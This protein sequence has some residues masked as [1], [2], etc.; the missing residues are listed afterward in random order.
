[1]SCVHGSAISF[2]YDD[3]DSSGFNWTGRRL[4]P[5]AKRRG[6]VEHITFSGADQDRAVAYDYDAL[7][8]LS[9]E[10]IRKSGDAGWPAFAPTML[11]SSPVSGDILYDSAVGYSDSGGYDKVGN[12]GS[13]TSSGVNVVT[14]SGIQALQNQSGLNYDANDRMN[15][16]A[17]PPSYDANGNTKYQA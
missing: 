5:A 9:A 13:R 6:V 8:R 7:G 14:A 16:V 3:F 12:R 15:Y 10:R 4:T 2:D 1:M 17:S 11:P